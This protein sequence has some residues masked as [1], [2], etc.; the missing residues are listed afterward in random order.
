VT[1][2]V[3]VAPIIL[4]PFSA[5]TS[6]FMAR[7]ADVEQLLFS[8]AVAGSVTVQFFLE[9]CVAVFHSM[10]VDLQSIQN[11]LTGDNILLFLLVNFA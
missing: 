9:N 10:R 5:P 3:L 1:V 7:P 4:R 6:S 8:A 11:N 2:S